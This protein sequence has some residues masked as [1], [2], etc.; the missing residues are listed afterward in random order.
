MDNIS[1]VNS[2]SIN[3]IHKQNFLNQKGK[4]LWFTGLSGSGKTTLAKALEIELFKRGY[5][6]VLIDGDIIRLGLNSDLGFSLKEREENIRRVAEISKL[7]CHSGV[8]CLNCFIS[9]T[10]KI[11]KLAKEIIGKNDFIEI[12]VDA[13]LELCEKR[14][15]KGLYSK[16]RK[17]EIENFTGIS[18]DYEV[19]EFPDI[20]I[21]TSKLNI[22]KSVNKIF[23][24]IFE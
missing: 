12:F 5:L 13:P 10:N 11:R 15:V 21:N 22:E 1:P 23:K 7:F 3:R 16:A 6:T 4:V 17:G 9:P 19:P 24:S 8:I 18:A 2:V 14:D 20:V